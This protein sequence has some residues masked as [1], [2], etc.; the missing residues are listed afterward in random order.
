[1]VLAIA[2]LAS[3]YVTGV[4]L[5]FLALRDKYVWFEDENGELHYR[6]TTL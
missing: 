1:M 4:C 5:V 3:F 6:L 2:F